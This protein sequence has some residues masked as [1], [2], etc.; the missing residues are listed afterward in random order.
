MKG[1]VQT[2]EATGYLHVS[3]FYQERGE[4]SSASEA[5]R[6]PKKRV[7]FKVTF[8]IAQRGTGDER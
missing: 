8:A 1:K 3:S 2:P 7:S 6:S 4:K 5:A